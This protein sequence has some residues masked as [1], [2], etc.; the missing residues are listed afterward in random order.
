M[1]I[2]VKVN[3]TFKPGMDPKVASYRSW[4]CARLLDDAA[5]RNAFKYLVAYYHG[6]IVGTFCIH[7]VSKDNPNTSDK[8][9]VRFL[10]EATENN[11]DRYL[12][13]IVNKLISIGSQK[14]K[15]SISFCYIDTLFLT[16]NNISVENHDCKCTIEKIEIKNEDEIPLLHHEK[17]D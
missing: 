9:K 12:K 4:S 3:Q 5:F 8:R 7:G 6:E 13:D 14:I 15:R 10:L 2:L 16:Q 17:I 11:C 1:I